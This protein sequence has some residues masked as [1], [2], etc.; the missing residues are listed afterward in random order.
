M[1]PKLSICIPTYNRVADL[2][3]LL[4]S[5]FAQFEPFKNKVELFVSDNCSTDGTP[6]LLKKY[7][8]KGFPFRY[9]INQENKGPDFNFCQCFRE[10]KGE[11]FWLI[12]S[13]DFLR[14]EALKVIF[15]FLESGHYDLI[16]LAAQGYKNNAH[17]EIIDSIKVNRFSS[18]VKFARKIGVFFTF[19]SGNIINRDTVLKYTTFAEMEVYIGTLFVQLAWTY[20]ALARGDDFLFISTPLIIAKES[21]VGYS[22]FELFS[23]NLIFITSQEL[24]RATLLS[25][26]IMDHIICRFFPKYVIDYRLGK[27][28]SQDD[29]LRGGSAKTL[30]SE[31][32]SK[33]PAFWFFL[34]PLLILPIPLARAWRFFV[35]VICKV[36]L[37]CLSIIEGFLCFKN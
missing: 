21:V 1:L 25:N 14:P 3:V 30:L 26:G 5:I 34:Y 20:V 28:H 7:Q 10:A 35:R 36:Y 37:L 17:L 27:M 23:K 12:G 18:N 19:I 13:D 29:F 31:S 33:R 16:H 11:Y 32:F 6:E 4:D 8:N 22:F 9:M 2:E 24:G 15:S